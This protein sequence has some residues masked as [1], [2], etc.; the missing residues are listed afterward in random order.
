ME[1]PDHLSSCPNKPEAGSGARSGPV[2]TVEGGWEKRGGGK[3]DL[4]VFH[5]M[6]LNG[7]FYIMEANLHSKQALVFNLSTERQ[8]K[9]VILE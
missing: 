6:F 4:K 8:R 1:S 5:V 3:A 2:F 7:C 9:A